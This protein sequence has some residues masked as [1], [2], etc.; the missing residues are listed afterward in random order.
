MSFHCH[1]LHKLV[2]VVR[3][4]DCLPNLAQQEAHI[5][6][7]QEHSLAGLQQS[8]GHPKQ[9]LGPLIQQS[10]PHPSCSL[11]QALHSA[12]ITLCSHHIFGGAMADCAAFPIAFASTDGQQRHIWPTDTHMDRHSQTA[13]LAA[14][15]WASWQCKGGC[16]WPSPTF[17]TSKGQPQ[18]CHGPDTS[19]VTVTT[20]GRL[21]C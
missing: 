18:W 15:A 8:Q 16:T 21:H 12:C 11:Q 1:H 5:V 20:H 7:L 2:S 10:I 14:T 6:L 13:S 9:H 17:G 3:V 19:G 4:C